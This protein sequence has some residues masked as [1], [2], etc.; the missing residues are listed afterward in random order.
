MAI[1]KPISDRLWDDNTSPRHLDN[2]CA[3]LF[4]LYGSAQGVDRFMER[5]ERSLMVPYIQ[6]YDAYQIN[7][8]HQLLVDEY[9]RNKGGERA[10]KRGRSPGAVGRDKRIEELNQQRPWAQPSQD[11]ALDMLEDEANNTPAAREEN[12]QQVVQSFVAPDLSKYA[13]WHAL[14]DYAKVKQLNDV[15]EAITNALQADYNRLEKA[16]ADI[17]LQ[18][19]TIVTLERR[20]LPP[21]EAGIQH[22]NFP[23]LMRAVN[24]IN[25]SGN[26]LNVWLHGPAGT[27]KTTAAEKVADLL[28]L[29]Y[30]Y[31]GA[32]MSAF[33]LT[34]YMDANG[35]YVTTAFRKAWEH[36]GV[37]LFDEIDGSM[38]DALLAMNGALANGI[39]SFPDGMVPRHKDCIIIAGANTTGLGGGIEYVGAMK[40]NAA[41]LNR[42]V[43]IAWPHDDALEDALCADKEW[44]ARVRFVRERVKTQGNKGHLITMRASLFGEALLAG[45]M[46]RI[47]VED[48]TLK[49]G[50][51]DAQWNAVK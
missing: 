17:D 27:G 51:S 1:S 13:T 36:G 23:K 9:A 21:I 15:A 33:Q 2:L 24:S 47:D 8:A 35:K 5:S 50:M 19:P 38:P 16:I 7:R 31:N 20:E 30:H 29:P 34:G 39:A 28:S 26:H 42:F 18:K 41:F 48:A 22:R 11:N 3:R 25:R 6:R 37:Y 49:Q 44:L 14:N 12:A 40:Q 43:F 10:F 4:Q 46:D 32:L 45:G